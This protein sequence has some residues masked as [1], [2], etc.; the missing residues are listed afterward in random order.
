MTS[1][2]IDDSFRRNGREAL[3]K[4]N[5]WFDSLQEEHL[6]AVIGSLPS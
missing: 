5:A 3:S 2:L 6:A 4:M 1:D